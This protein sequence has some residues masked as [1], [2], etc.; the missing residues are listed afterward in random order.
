MGLPL[1]TLGVIVTALGGYS[2]EVAFIG[3]IPN[4]LGTMPA[5]L[6]YMSLIIL[7][8]G[9]ADD[10]LKRRLRAVGRM[11]L[12]NY[13]TQTLFG[14]LILTI[15]LGDNDSVGRAALLLFVFA[16]WA[17]QLWWS[18]AWLGRFLFG[19]AEWLWRVATYRR[20][21]PLRRAS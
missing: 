2:R 13:L 1:A 20:G 8:D 9:R 4:T 11:A 5:A 7:W 14:A 19:P 21:Q 10:W 17:A 16:V 18:Q 15:L 6:G 3:Q 12:T